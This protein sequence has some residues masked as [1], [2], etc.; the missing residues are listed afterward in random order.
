MDISKYIK[1]LLALN[2]I[3]IKKLAVLLSEK[4]GTNYTQSGLTTKIRRGKVTLQEGFAIADI[5]GYNLEF[6]KK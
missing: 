4:T 1:S 3:T 2:G 5:L 6:I